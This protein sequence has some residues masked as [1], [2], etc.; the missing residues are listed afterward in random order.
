LKKQIISES[1]KNGKL[2]GLTSRARWFL[3][4]YIAL[5]ML[6]CELLRGVI[7][8]L[9]LNDTGRVRVMKGRH[10]FESDH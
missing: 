9:R 4:S 5:R 8:K 6:H 1:L 7:T 10:L 2:A 3:V